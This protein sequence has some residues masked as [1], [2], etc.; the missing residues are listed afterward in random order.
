MQSY[1]QQVL[2]V[3]D[4]ILDKYIQDVSNKYNINDKELRKMW[5]NEVDESVKDSESESV[6]KKEEY[7]K[8]LAKKSKNELVDMCKKDDVDAKGTKKDLVAKLVNKKF[9]KENVVENI[10]KNMNAIIIKKNQW[11]N[12]EHTLTKLVFNKTTKT[13]FGK[14]HDDG[15]VIKLTREDIDMCNKYKFKYNIPVDLGN[16]TE[17]MDLENEI[18]ESDE[19]FEEDEED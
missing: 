17:D 2:S 18:S 14:Q 6:C 16:D 7:K 4:T 1:S 3:V 11:G 13:V 8:T 9:R 12:Y 19:E 5:D 15:N 10:S